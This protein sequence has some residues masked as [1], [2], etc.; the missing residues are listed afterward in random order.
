MQ[1]LPEIRQ[2]E[3]KRQEWDFDTNVNQKELNIWRSNIH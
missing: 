2:P 3:R 1:Q